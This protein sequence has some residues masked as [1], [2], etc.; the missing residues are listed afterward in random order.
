MWTEI[1][2]V[3]EHQRHELVLTGPDVAKRIAEAGLDEHLY[4]LVSVNFLEISKTALTLLDSRLGNLKNLTRLVLHY[5]KLKELPESLGK[6][7]KLKFL[8]VSHN[9]IEELPEVFSSLTEL[10]S[11]NASVNLLGKIADLSQCVHLTYVDVSHNKL[12]D[13]PENLCSGSL[14]NLLDIKLNANQM[15]NVSPEITLLTGL[16]QM[17]L[18]VN[19]ITV[20]PKELSECQKLKEVLLQDN[21]LKDARLKKLIDQ[22]PPKFKAVLDYIRD[23]CAPMKTAAATEAAAG[24]AKAAGKSKNKKKD[25]GG[26]EEVDVV[27]DEIV[28]MQGTDESK[29]V[30]CK[31]SVAE[32]RPYIVCCIIRNLQLDVPAKLKKFISIQTDLHDDLCDKRMAATIATH[33]LDLIKGDITYEARPPRAIKLQPLKRSADVSA[34]VLVNQLRDE[35]DALRKEKKRSTYSGIHKYLN[36]LQDKTTYPCLVAAD[37][38]VI[39]FPPI[40][41]SDKTKI[42]PATK[43]VLVEVTGSKSLAVC[44]A[45]M[46]K[47]LLDCL[48]AGLV[49]IEGEKTGTEE[50][51]DD[52]V[53]DVTKA[54]AAV[55]VT[56]SSTAAKVLIVEQVKVFEEAG[57]LKV[58]YPSRVDLNVSHVTVTRS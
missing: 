31:P 27:L 8:D 9:E 34:E 10:H 17:D 42:S 46:D 49:V 22:K 45:V 33:D 1:Q 36:L 57:E 48:K 21:P 4:N 54:V 50:S 6:L 58:V 3:Q 40:T 35:A 2:Q 43:N 38:T 20:L 52:D 51:G 26:D 47:L 7:S 24:K 25:G 11:I 53:E 37:G 18:S 13:F 29:R 16:K 32:V 41:N 19:R 15:R 28:I 14:V 44:K 30:V 12:E 56:P 23:H 55:A 39:S 5:N